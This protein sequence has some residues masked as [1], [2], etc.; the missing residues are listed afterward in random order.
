VLIPAAALIA[1]ANR[2]H[3]KPIVPIN[4]T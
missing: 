3:L 4:A 1:F 2:D